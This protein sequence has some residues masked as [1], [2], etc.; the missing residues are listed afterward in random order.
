[1]KGNVWRTVLVLICFL[2]MLPLSAL[3]EAEQSADEPI[4]IE[5]TVN[6]VPLED[7]LGAATEMFTDAVEE[8]VDEAV[9]GLNGVF[10]DFARD[11]TGALG[12]M[13]TVLGSMDERW[14]LKMPAIAFDAC[15][16]RSA[17]ADV[18]ELYDAQMNGEADTESKLA[19]KSTET[20]GNSIV[21]V[22]DEGE[23]IPAILQSMQ[24]NVFDKY[25]V[26]FG[27]E[28]W[29]GTYEVSSVLHLPPSDELY[30]LCG[31]TDLTDEAQFD[32]FRDSVTGLAMANYEESIVYGDRILTVVFWPADAEG[33]WLVFVAK[34]V[35]VLLD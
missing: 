3:G 11:M 7:W 26:M 33:D 6:D 16:R 12:E 18:Q 13:E 21:Y 17:Y 1:M 30:A 15:I 20:S 29:I 19:M 2:L 34:E 4:E 10:A 32:A 5:I 31:M 28:G 22:R 14:Y 9:E 35:P 8:N 27:L 25:E 23:I 24:E